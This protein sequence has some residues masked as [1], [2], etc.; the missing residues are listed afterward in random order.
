MKFCQNSRGEVKIKPVLKIPYLTSC[1]S[2][3]CILEM[4]DVHM[5]KLIKACKQYALMGGAPVAY[6]HGN[7]CLCVC[8]SFIHI[9]LQWLSTISAKTTMQAVT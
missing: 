5:H 8:M 1:V 4:T 9:S 6:I 2:N 7:V 3:K